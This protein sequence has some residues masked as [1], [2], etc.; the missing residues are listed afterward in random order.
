MELHHQAEMPTDNVAVIIESIL[1]GESPYLKYGI[2]LMQPLFTNRVA[3]DPQ[4]LATSSGVKPMDCIDRRGV[5]TLMFGAAAAATIGSGLDVDV[6][7]AAPLPL[8]TLGTG[9]TEDSDDILQQA[10]FGP[11]PRRRHPRHRRGFG[12]RRRWDCWWRKGRRVCG[13]RSW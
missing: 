12:P 4:I 3:L 8:G 1:I 6:A 10:Q 9:Q 13:W 7:E 5:L 2:S 11:P